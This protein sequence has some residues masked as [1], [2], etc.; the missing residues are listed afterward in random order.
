M[1]V[2]K[3]GNKYHYR[4]MVEGKN[5][6]GVCEGCTTK[7]E[8]EA[9]EKKKRDLEAQV[10][11]PMTD[12]AFA[13]KVRGIRRKSAQDNIPLEDGLSEAL[14]ATC[15]IRNRSE[16]H[17]VYL[18][19]IW[20]DF[21]AFLA[22]AEPNAKY[23]SDV[24]VK[25]AEDY[26]DHLRNNGR[27]STVEY[28]RG[29]KKLTQKTQNKMSDRTISVYIT[30]LKSV[31]TALKSKAQ[32]YENPFE[33]IKQ[34]QKDTIK[35]EVFTEDDLQKMQI[36]FS[37]DNIYGEFC[38]PLF[39]VSLNTG[40]R[41]GDICNL[42]WNS[43]SFEN[44]GWI[45]LKTRKTGSTVDVPLLP[46]LYNF[47]VDEWNKTKDHSGYVF[48]THAE[49]YKNNPSGVSLR[50]KTFLRGA[51]VEGLTV[52]NGTRNVSVKDLHS[53]RHTFIFRA[54]LAGLPLPII[55]QLVGHADVEMTKHYMRHA[56][57]ADVRKHLSNYHVL[58]CESDI[59]DITAEDVTN[60]ARKEAINIIN[61]MS[62]EEIEEFL[63]NYRK[64]LS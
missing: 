61:Q 18:K 51:G 44:D 37:N 57:R 30:T 47:L 41:E 53:C 58:S 9:Y 50:I 31:F 27:F 22:V 28:I 15:G 46:E 21:C 48:P 38:R 16:K 24:T 39:T 63:K 34:K 29:G 55:E 25:N 23:I 17:T 14:K 54:T 7:R 11:E 2:R 59:I 20:A 64:K 56:N 3:R 13:E 10:R 45:T 4:F 52:N 5:Y 49:M 35:R 36:A 42:L 8:A 32:L 1:A 43:V 33:H 60:E 26:I 19:S 6:S 40:L 12:V 62:N